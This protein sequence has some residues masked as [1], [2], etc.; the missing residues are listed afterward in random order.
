MHSKFFGLKQIII[1]F[2]ILCLPGCF[3]SEKK[4]KE[5]LSTRNGSGAS[6]NIENQSPI[7]PITHMNKISTI[8]Q[9]Y[10]SQGFRSSEILV[11]F[12]IDETLLTSFAEK[13]GIQKGIT[14]R[15]LFIYIANTM[16]IN[17]I[18][19]AKVQKIGI[20]NI[21][22]NNKELPNF[23]DQSLITATQKKAYSIFGDLHKNQLISSKPVEPN[24]DSLINQ[25]QK[26]G[27]RVMGLTARGLDMKDATL[28]ELKTA[29]IQLNKRTVYHKDLNLINNY[30]GFRKGILFSTPGVEGFDKG[31][32]L[33]KLLHTI[34]YQPK[35]IIFVDDNLH[36]I[37][38]VHD[39]LKKNYHDTLFTGLW[40]QF[41]SN[42][43]VDKAL[44]EQ[45]INQLHG[46]QWWLLQNYS[47][48]G[49]AQKNRIQP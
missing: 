28:A 30:H 41:T 2:S 8:I 24:I 31:K 5:A 15:D 33:I 3:E 6:L 35:V 36:F 43:E 44:A 45:L 7:Q 38:S 11:I 4:Q 23:V 48:H 47:V 49:Q 46:K 16:L 34:K 21:H 14:S 26:D 18:P 27:T 42:S 39:A 12:D 13:N 29:N 20:K 40:Y 37:E 22:I 32:L 17:H 25:L 1:T 9:D 19:P 10:L